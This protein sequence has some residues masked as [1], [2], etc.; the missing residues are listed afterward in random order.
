[1]EQKKIAD[2]LKA[3]AAAVAVVGILFFFWYVPTLIGEYVAMA[4]ELAYLRWPGTI[5]MWV[6]AVLCYGA[7]WE[8]WKICTQIGSDNSFCKENAR[9][10]KRIAQLAFLAAFLILAGGVFLACTG[11]LGLTKAMKVFFVITAACGLGV[12]CLALARLIQNAA[13]IKEENDLTI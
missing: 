10:M 9:S 2:I 7:L 3:S 4:P 5:G 12:I 13:D 1:M 6:I 11:C 8:F